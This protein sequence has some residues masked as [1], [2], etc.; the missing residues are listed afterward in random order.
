VSNWGRWTDAA[1]RGIS[2]GVDEWRVDAELAGVSVLGAVA[3]AGPGTLRSPV[4]FD[5][6]AR[7]VMLK[8]RVPPAIADAV[9]GAVWSG[10]KEW[11]DAVTVP[12]LPWYPAFALWPMPVAPPTP[13]VPMPLCLCVSG[14]L[15]AM[16]PRNLMTDI[17][18]RIG[19]GAMTEG[20]REGI[21]DIARDIHAAFAT[22][23]G[24]ALVTLAFGAGSAPVAPPFVPAQPVHG[25]VINNGRGCLAAAVPFP[26]A[27]PPRPR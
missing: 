13:N 4:A 12:G 5:R 9:A 16:S 17:E 19:P 14:R 25:R 6:T 22:W 8:S 23:I 11:A 18:A 2:L 10:W 21:D 3:I 24:Q 1:L 26:D 15:D 20:V 7:A 27:A